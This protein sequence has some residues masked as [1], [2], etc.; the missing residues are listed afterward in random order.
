MAT[1]WENVVSLAREIDDAFAKGREPDATIV[2]RLA[3]AVVDFQR[4]LSG[5][6]LSQRHQPSSEST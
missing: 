1:R 4:D 3:R 2:S 5:A 6:P